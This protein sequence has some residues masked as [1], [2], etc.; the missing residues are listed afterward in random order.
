MPGAATA[1]PDVRV[2]HAVR[3]TLPRRIAAT[4]LLT[5]VVVAA[6]WPPARVDFV[7]DDESFVASNSAVRSISAAARAA[8]QPFPP[9]DA[10][11][12]LYRP[13]T[14]LSYGLD[15]TLWGGAPRSFA[16]VNLALYLAV[17]LTAWRFFRGQLATGTAAFAAALLFAAHPVHAEAVDAITGRSELLALLFSLLALELFGAPDSPAAGTGGALRGHWPSW[18]PWLSALAFAFACS[19]KEGAAV[20]PAILAAHVALLRLEGRL[21]PGGLRHG[22]AR[23][24]P[25]LAVLA[26]YLAVRRLVL[27]G[28]APSLHVLGAADPAAR[29]FTGGA[30]FAE[31]LRLLLFPTSL[32]P[33]GY[34]LD[35]IGI[36]RRLTFQA[37][38]GWATL[39][40]LLALAIR[41]TRR[42]ARAA[43]TAPRSAPGGVAT[44]A[45]LVRGLA[46]F[47]GF[48]LPVSHIFPFG[49]LM[50]ERF[51]F[52]PSLGFVL[53]LVAA[54]S[55]LGERRGGRRAALASLALPALAA[56][57]LLGAW[58]SRA[59]SL[60]WRD[61]VRFWE[62]EEQATPHDFRV[63]INLGAERLVRGDL[64]GAAQALTGALAIRPLDGSVAFNL[65]QVALRR[66]DLV[67]AA[68][69]FERLLA[70][71]PDDLSSLI[72]LAG[73]ELRRAHPARATA[74]LE[75]ARTLAA[76]RP[77]FE[78]R[79]LALER[80]LR[81]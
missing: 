72:E 39:A 7:F 49:A 24:L 63:K 51:L 11:R 2:R 70:R 44:E 58:R 17:C 40:V 56:L 78:Q 9:D 55:M 35:R 41:L 37:A 4:L 74:L 23:L 65:A 3:R 57:V 47:F 8:L 13:L 46:V 71:D 29:A 32:H 54:A 43:A 21:E 31:Y 5:T 16:F 25:H 67:T 15:W 28:F 26:A 30:V 27:G 33:D 53:A 76:G 14:A 6:H 79:I 36:L 80:V 50:A 69:A 12:G 42:L 68:A 75:R 38:A 45:A 64:D 18:R 34:Y 59:R 1:P 66:G 62:V 81:P 77:R 48:L 73:V 22:L 61:A 19:A 20:L 10:Q 60:E 52:A